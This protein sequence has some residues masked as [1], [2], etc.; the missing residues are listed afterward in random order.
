MTQSTYCYLYDW[1]SWLVFVVYLLCSALALRV[2][3]DVMDNG[4]HLEWTT[5]SMNS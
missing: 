4:E 1:R 5:E 2:V 3:M